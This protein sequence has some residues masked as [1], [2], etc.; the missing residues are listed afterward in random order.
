MVDF[1]FVDRGT[2]AREQSILEMHSL[3]TD[4]VHFDLHFITGQRLGDTSLRC[5]S[6]K[7][8]VEM[9]EIIF[10]LAKDNMLYI[11]MTF[12]FWLY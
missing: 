10:N 9:R 7:N 1:I 4:I 3:Q 8:R 12:R 2:P 6:T 5:T 11:F